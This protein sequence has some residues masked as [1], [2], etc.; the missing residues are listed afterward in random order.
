M[1]KIGRIAITGPT[2]AVGIAIIKQMIAQNV[3]V[4]AICNPQSYRNKHIPD[5]PLVKLIPCDLSHLN[6]LKKQRV[7][8]LILSFLIWITT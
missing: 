6:E 3:E 4:L 1:Q 8:E 5:N 7:K 2:G